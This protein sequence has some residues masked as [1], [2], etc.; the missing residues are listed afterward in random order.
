MTQIFGTICAYKKSTMLKLCGGYMKTLMLVMMIFSCFSLFASEDLGQQSK[1]Q[2]I[3]SSNASRKK[4][5]DKKKDKSDEEVT[6][7]SQVGG[8]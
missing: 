2:C 3:H 6:E 4:V 5:A 7:S 1:T 8:I